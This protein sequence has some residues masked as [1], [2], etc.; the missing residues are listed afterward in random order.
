[1][2]IVVTGGC[3][4]IG[5]HLAQALVMQGHEVT[6]LDDLSTGKREYA[7]REAR[8]VLGDVADVALVQKLIRDAQAV[9]HLAAVASVER[10]HQEWAAA[11]RTNVMG[12]IAVLDAAR[13]VS[14]PVV[15]ASSAAVYG[16]N[17]SLPLRETSE[18]APKSFYGLDKLTV[19][20]YA[21]MAWETYGLSSAGIRFFNVYGPR[22]DPHSPY[23]GVITR[24]AQRL[25]EHKP[26]ILYGDGQQTRD[27]IH[28]S[29]AVAL[30]EAAL[31]QPVSAGAQYYNGCTGVSTSLTQLA[32]L[33]AQ[34]YGHPPAFVHE[35]ARAGDIL[36]SR[37]CPEFA[38]VRLG[39]RA[40]QRL[41]DIYGELT[42]TDSK[43]A[44][45]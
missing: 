28:V 3:G 39:F 40:L 41:Q 9:V 38:A 30:L 2:K 45:S 1:M 34:S 36:H 29:D 42:I 16:N 11:H 22:Q 4:F 25:S 33:M 21:L 32:A 8:L 7:P 5:S 24:F 6:I 37:G 31:K 23:S 12:S 20:K 17:P 18:T 10:C 13:Q 14:I 35:P 15:Y 27:F 19:E 43:N 26:L 44:I